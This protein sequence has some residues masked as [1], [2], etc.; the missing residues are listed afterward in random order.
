VGSKFGL[1][2]PAATVAFAA[3]GAVD[4]MGT[5]AAAGA[6]AA[7]G[8]FSAAGR[9]AVAGASD[10]E[11]VPVPPVPWASAGAP[12]KMPTSI[13]NPAVTHNRLMVGRRIEA[14]P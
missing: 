12:T 6:L 4:V 10:A 3:V 8:T 13:S 14:F 5:L 11:P 7:V 9:F 2:T 1:L